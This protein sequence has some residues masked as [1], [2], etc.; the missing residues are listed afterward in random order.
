M[1]APV[2]RRSMLKAAAAMAGATLLAACGSTPTPTP[3]PQKP[4]AK[5]TDTPVKAVPTPVAMKGKLTVLFHG[6]A[7]LDTPYWQ[8]RLKMFTDAYPD[9]E[10]IWLG[11]ETDEA[12]TQK[13]TT[14][15]AGGTPP[16]GAKPSGG[17][18]IA[19]A[20][21]GIYEALEPRIQASTL[22][23]KVMKLLP[24]EGKELRFCG[25]Q[26]AI[27]MDNDHRVWF[28]NKDIFDK[29]GVKYP[30]IDWTWEDLLAIG[31]AVTKPADNQ[32]LFVPG[33]VSFQDYA[34]WVWQAGG[35]KFSNDCLHTNLSEAPNIKGMQF[36]VDLFVKYKFAPSPGLK[37]G[38]VGVSFDSG[39]IAMNMG[40]TSTLAAQLGPKATW[41]FNWSCV[42]APKG[43]VTSNGFAKSNGWSVM[44][45]AKSPNLAWALIE[46]WFKDETMTKFAEMGE[47]VARSDIRDSVS[48]KSVPEHVRPALA[49]ATRDGRGLERCPGWDVA[50][51]NWKQ[52]LD[53]AISGGVPV[54]QAMQTADKKAELEIADLMKGIC[55][56]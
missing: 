2:S 48:I 5:P 38:D 32:Y 24:S 31:Q 27:P 29:A 23:T 35:T 41:K 40:A 20:P 25:K 42:F 4:A 3:A 54:E 50:Q 15:V 8:P 39:K 1:T 14:M 56:F 9:L 17:R 49:R 55:D 16:D 30:T 18:M 51:R 26:Y 53:T 33:V 21:K 11:S 28:Y 13:I 10:C 36:L 52:E 34:D 43:P 44:K 7:T 37:L 45:S 19:T 22:M 12:F 47:L 46:W 6:A